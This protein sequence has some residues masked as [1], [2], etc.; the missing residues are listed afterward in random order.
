MPAAALPA[1][2]YFSSKVIEQE[3]HTIYP[4]PAFRILMA[5]SK[6]PYYSMSTPSNYFP[7]SN[8]RV[9]NSWDPAPSSYN[10]SNA[11]DALE[12]FA[13]VNRALQARNARQSLPRR[14]PQGPREPRAPNP[15]SSPYRPRALKKEQL[16]QDAS[17]LYPRFMQAHTSQEYDVVNPRFSTVSSPPVLY[18]RRSSFSSINDRET[19]RYDEYPADHVTHSGELWVEQLTGKRER[20]RTWDTIANP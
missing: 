10:V 11:G 16:P 17:Q 1:C 14:V 13:D 15:E 4:P 8:S 18:P 6:H 19:G 20:F 2:E 5:S 7:P 9:P 12:A 3:T